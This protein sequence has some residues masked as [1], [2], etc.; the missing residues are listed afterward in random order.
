LNF[1]TLPDGTHPSDTCYDFW[2]NGYH[3]IFLGSDTPSGLNAY[4]NEQTLAWLD[5]KLAENRNE[6]RPTFVFLHQGIYNTVAGT[7]PGEGWHGVTNE[8]EFVEVI[9]KYPEVVMFNGHSHWELESRGNIFEGT[10]DLP[11]RAFNCASVSYLWTAFNKTSGE[12]RDGSQGYAVDV[13]DSK[14]VVRGRDF[15]NSEWVSGAQYC[16]EFESNCE[17]DYDEIEIEYANGFDKMG[18]ITFKCSLCSLE[19][20]ESCDKMLTPIG[21]SIKLDTENGYG[22]SGGYVINQKLRALYESI[23]EVALDLGI[24]VLNPE[25]VT[26]NSFMAN[27]LIT[28][29]ER[30]LQVSITETSV[31]TINIMIM[32]IDDEKVDL[33]LVICAYVL[34]KKNDEITDTSFIQAETKMAVEEFAKNDATLYSVSYNSVVAKLQQ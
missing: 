20:N 4:F 8:A 21:Y 23:N 33:D 34:K 30:A 17:H 10:S 7:L 24:I 18:K 26:S 28:S 3:Y 32:G 16:I 12:N 29:S 22:L 27:G 9:K 31:T 1:A 6:A 13:Y 25:Y 15:V 5:E 2:L 11:I 19:K 14:V